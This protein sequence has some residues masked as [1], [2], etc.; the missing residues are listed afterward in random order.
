MID[1]LHVERNKVDVSSHVK[2]SLYLFRF[3]FI[4]AVSIVYE[5]PSYASS[6]VLFWNSILYSI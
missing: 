6:N 2:S 1:D 3:P 5:Q 4:Y